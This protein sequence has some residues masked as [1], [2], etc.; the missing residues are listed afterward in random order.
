MEKAKSLA[1]KW[2]PKKYVLHRSMASDS[3]ELDI[4][5]DRL[6]ALHG[7]LDDG[8]RRACGVRLRFVLVSILPRIIV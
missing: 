4:F 1:A 2:I 8:H 5:E 6:R 7:V 3:G